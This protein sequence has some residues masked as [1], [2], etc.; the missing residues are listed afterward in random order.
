[1]KVVVPI[2]ND[3]KSPVQSWKLSDGAPFFLV[4]TFNE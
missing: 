1:M 4:I 3:R 2:A